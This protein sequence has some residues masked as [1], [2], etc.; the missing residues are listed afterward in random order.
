MRVVF[1]I[2]AG[3]L[4]GRVFMFEG[5]DVFLVGRSPTAHCRFPEDDPY[6]SRFHFL[7]E[8]NP[9]RCRLT[10]MSSRKDPAA[11]YSDV[12]AFNYAMAPFGK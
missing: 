12:E 2:T 7:I 1:T 6:F 8:V 10:D 4:A 11:R 3:P 9:P 5:H